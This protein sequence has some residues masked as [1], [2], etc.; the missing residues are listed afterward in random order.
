[1]LNVLQNLKNNPVKNLIKMFSSFR[2]SNAKKSF[3]IFM[4]RLIFLMQY[5]PSIIPS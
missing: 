3:P 1:M 5:S 2:I 4:S